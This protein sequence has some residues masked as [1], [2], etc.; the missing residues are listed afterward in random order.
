MLNESIE[1]K[2]TVN[3]S[4]ETKMTGYEPIHT[5]MTYSTIFNV[6]SNN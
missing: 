6:K 2:M 5:Q 4:I 3:E 1:T